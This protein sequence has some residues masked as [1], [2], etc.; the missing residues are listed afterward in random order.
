MGI[1]ARLFGWLPAEDRSGIHLEEPDPWEVDATTDVERFLRALPLLV[2][3]G[4]FAYFEG[5]GEPHVAEY[6]R[7]ISVPPPVKVA[8]GTIW[9]RPDCH[10]VPISMPTMESLAGFLD[11]RPA[12]FVCAHCHVHDGVSVLLE[13]HDAFT[14]GAM[15]VS[16]KIEEDRVSSFAAALA[17]S[18]RP[19]LHP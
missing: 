19:A 2:P 5:T 15:L 7:S 13:W 8:L 12:G 18:Y 11:E 3:A 6:L 14:N 4:A 16:R 17:T 9:P 10:H 1:F